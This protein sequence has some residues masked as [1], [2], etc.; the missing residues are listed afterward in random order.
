MRLSTGPASLAC[1]SNFRGL[2]HTC[3]LFL[4]H[5]L[6]PLSPRL[7]QNQSGGQERSHLVTDMCQAYG[8]YLGIMQ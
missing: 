4:F 7:Q 3:L 6:P 2:S 1:L 8:H 5:V